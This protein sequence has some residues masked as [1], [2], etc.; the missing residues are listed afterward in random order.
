M[1]IARVPIPYNFL[2]SIYIIFI[3]FNTCIKITYF[4][5]T[6]VLIQFFTLKKANCS[7][8]VKHHYRK[9]KILLQVFFTALK[10]VDYL[11]SV[12]S[13]SLNINSKPHQFH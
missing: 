11:L 2:K 9:H 4:I 6:W 12:N 13:Y 8:F 7:E 10:V 1:R 3:I 5:S